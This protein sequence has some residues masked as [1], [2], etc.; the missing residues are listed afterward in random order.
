M[1]VCMGW[2]IHATELWLKSVEIKGE[3]KHGS[4]SP[5]QVGLGSWHSSYI[6]MMALCITIMVFQALSVVFID[7]P[8]RNTISVYP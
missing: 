5:Q 7:F 3:Q 6:S 2:E 8:R 1:T 4:L